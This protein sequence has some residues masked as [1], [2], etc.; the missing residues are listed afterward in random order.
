MSRS[1]TLLIDK[2]NLIR[3]NRRHLIKMDSKFVKTEND[4]DMDNDTEIEPETRHSI[5][6]TKPGKPSRYGE[7]QTVKMLL[8]EGGSHV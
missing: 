3:R 8:V 6:A 5:S 7:Y 2:D 4:N 1:H